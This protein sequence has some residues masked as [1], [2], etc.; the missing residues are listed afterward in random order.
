[1]SEPPLGSMTF[2]EQ[3]SGEKHKKKYSL[4]ASL[5]YKLTSPSSS[6]L[7]KDDRRSKKRSLPNFPY[8]Q[9]VPRNQTHSQL[10][11]YEDL[12]LKKSKD[13][14][15]YGTSKTKE[16]V[17]DFEKQAIDNACPF[18]FTSLHTSGKAYRNND[19]PHSTGSIENINVGIT[20]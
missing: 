17:A 16:K 14:Q 1:M 11:M 12:F 2:S 15:K 5:G 4:P 10:L 20:A 19:E 9:N 13:Q 7:A 18:Y 8:H 6:S 3:L